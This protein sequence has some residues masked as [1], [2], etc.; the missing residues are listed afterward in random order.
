MNLSDSWF[1]SL[2]VGSPRS[3]AAAYTGEHKHRKRR[4]IYIHAS[5]GIRA[6]DPSI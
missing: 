1:D 6:H 2:D 3:K 4:Q 5:G